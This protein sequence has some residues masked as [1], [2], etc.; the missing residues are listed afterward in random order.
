MAILVLSAEQFTL[1]MHH[2][3]VKASFQRTAPVASTNG[4][5]K[6]GLC[7]SLLTSVVAACTGTI[8]QHYWNAIAA[9]VRSLR[10]LPC[11]SRCIEDNTIFYYF[12]TE[13][14]SVFMMRPFS[15][16]GGSLCIMLALYTNFSTHCDA[17]CGSAGG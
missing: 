12:C 13:F 3:I 14:G 6:I 4:C 11:L 16:T 5:T 1:R 8:L 2:C 17:Y 9:I 10:M 15:T 7:N